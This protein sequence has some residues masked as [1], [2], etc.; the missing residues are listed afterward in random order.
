MENNESKAKYFGEIVVILC[1]EI[2]ML[3][4]RLVQPI[5]W[6]KQVPL[7][8]QGLGNEL[9]YFGIELG[10]IIVIVAHFIFKISFKE[11]GLT[12]FKENIA[13]LIGNLCFV[14][15]CVGVSFL[16]SQFSKVT[17]FDGRSLALQIVANF[18]AIAF[19][20]ELVFRGFLFQA[21]L[22]LLNG[23]GILAS[24]ISGVLFTMTYMPSILISLNEVNTSVLLGALVIPLVLGIYLSLVYYYGR[25]LWIC[26]IIHG[27]CL[28]IAALE[29]DIFINFLAGIYGLGLFI[30]LIYKMVNYYRNGD[31]EDEDV[32]VALQVS[33]DNEA[34]SETDNVK[35]MDTQLKP[36]AMEE[37]EEQSKLKASN[38]V[39]K[40]SEEE[41]QREIVSPSQEEKQ[42]EMVT[43]SQEEK[44]KEM[45]R[46]SQEEKQREIV[47]P[48]QEEKQREIVSPSQE[49]KQKEMVRL[50][51]EEQQK[52]I[53]RPSEE[54]KPKEIV[55]VF[56]EE[57]QKEIVT[58]SQEEELEKKADV[59]KT[60]MLKEMIVSS[61]EVEE[62][63]S[64]HDSK[65]VEV[66]NFKNM[67]STPAEKLKHDLDEELEKTMI[68]PNLAKEIEEAM[69]IQ[70]QELEEEEDLGKIAA[71]PNTQEELGK[72][73]N[74]QARKKK[75][76]QLSKQAKDLDS[77]VIMPCITETD[78]KERQARF[79]PKD[80]ELM[81]QAEPNF[82][83][84]LEKYLGDFEGIYKQIIP[85]EWPIDILYFSGEKYNAIVTNGM[86]A[87]IMSVP[88]ELA[89]YQQAE[90]MMF[91]DKSFDLS[92]EGLQR[93]ENAWL[94]KLLTDLAIYPRQINSY[95]GWGHIVG[96]GEELEPYDAS[97]EYC[98]ALIYPPMVQ[99]DVAFYRYI[100]KGR[101]IFIYNVMPLFKDELRFIQ[102]HSS[103]QFINLMSEMSVK[104][105]VKP[106]RINVIKNMNRS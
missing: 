73:V 95:L 46:P 26:T 92:G 33:I 79:E 106:K 58:P 99:E 69:K 68:L 54:E 93:E 51:E 67:M 84:H 12:R 47:R 94:I 98:G 105:T 90:L 43:P 65:V 48:S 7:I 29:S 40:V 62:E 96:N 89:E 31:K 2:I 32:E 60:E 97:I 13:S 4:F 82:I 64:I 87:M 8:W 57:K 11:L 17:E 5:T 14:G 49:E 74:L 37:R 30:Y 3:L 71:I 18:V 83:A 101:N 88:P 76:E 21:M 1:L 104:Q 38:E 16:I 25:N 45:V 70:E 6:S 102:N 41:K 78:T 81:I 19:I 86:R 39:V 91:V 100:E 36:A 34:V 77:T 63:Q 9:I 72:V 61:K 80:V 42:K 56:E 20:R 53:A 15:L 23:K 103:D 50:S 28:S 10:L 75:M 66:P 52:E 55:K 59:S 22:K 85:T 27:V 44:Q 24:V 35:E